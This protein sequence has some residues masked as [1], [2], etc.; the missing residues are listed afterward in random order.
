MPR[1]K[2][3]TL[4]CWGN[5]PRH[6]CASARPES[7][8]ALDDA[9]RDDTHGTLIARGLGR[10][11][12]DA[13]LNEGGAVV[14]TER[15]DRALDFDENTGVL[16]AEAGLALRDANRAFL[17]R[18]WFPGVTPGSA[19]VT[20][21]GAIAANVHGKNHHSEGACAE[22][23]EAIELLLPDGDQRWV[24]RDDEPELF[25]ATLGGM[26]LT[27]VIRSAKIRLKHTPSAYIDARYTKAANLD[28]ALE[29]FAGDYGAM[30][31][32]VAWIDCLATGAHAGRSVLIGGDHAPVAALPGDLQ[33][34]PYSTNAP[35][36]RRVPFDFPSFALN[37][38]SVRA[39]NA[40]YY[41][42]SRP[43]RRIEPAHAFFYPLDAVLEWN[44]I[45]GKKGFQ[46][47]QV[48]IPFERGAEG[49]RTLLD[50][51]AK[52]K[53]ASF[54]AVL[55][56]MGDASEGPLSFPMPGWTLALDLKQTPRLDALLAD[57]DA[58][59]ID[60]GGRRY[61]AKDA[62]LSREHFERMYPRLD[63]FMSVRARV[64][65]RGR[66]S[67]SLSRRLGLDP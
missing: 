1:F 62:S 4:A 31:Y 66:L 41:R 44:R 39:F 9:L 60:F 23:T 40:L 65:P 14:R 55:K 51:I 34:Q 12:G 45:Y 26:G 57:L 63:E 53:A 46:Q 58:I 32:S 48:V 61:L 22:W 19:Y 25:H 27:G 49:V 20:V 21:G 59:T 33:R 15:L 38:L 18:G 7:W 17:P 54:L 37:P 47:Y 6:D 64:D 16:H 8:A 11:Y 2:D 29:G 36:R 43:E 28:E 30:P 50:R 52:A 67:S 5:H 56:A 24:S 10:S 42:T 35:K 13:A 3:E